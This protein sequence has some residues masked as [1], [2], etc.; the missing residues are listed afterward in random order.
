MKNILYLV[1]CVHLYSNHE[2]NK[3]YCGNL[4]RKKPILTLRLGRKGAEH[5]LITY[6]DTKAVV[7][8]KI[9]L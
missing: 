4:C 9:D 2:K 3:K 8:Y 6:I 5:G 7:I 1:V